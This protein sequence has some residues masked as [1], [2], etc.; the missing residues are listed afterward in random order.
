MAG[1]T[2]TSA[3]YTCTL[4]HLITC[5]HCFSFCYYLLYF[6]YWSM[7]LLHICIYFIL[8]YCCGYLAVEEPRLR[9]VLLCTCTTRCNKSHSDSD[10]DYVKTRSLR[11]GVHGTCFPGR[12]W[13]CFPISCN[14]N[15]LSGIGILYIHLS[16]TLWTQR[17]FAVAQMKWSLCTSK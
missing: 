7:L 10:P 4:L 12:H 14:R 11:S 1:T 5:Y 2:T 16:A 15:T 6:I 17:T 13:T 3:L 8:Y 9:I